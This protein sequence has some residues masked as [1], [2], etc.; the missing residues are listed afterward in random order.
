MLSLLCQI[1]KS[2]VNPQAELYFFEVGCTYKTCFL[3]LVTLYLYICTECE[4]PGKPT[5]GQHYFRN[6]Q[7][8]RTVTYSCDEGLELVGDQSRECLDTGRWSGSVPVCKCMHT[9]E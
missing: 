1:C 9:S 4:V 6:I 8:G 7:V 2:I 5:N 3:D